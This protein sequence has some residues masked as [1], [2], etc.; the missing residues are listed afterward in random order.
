M[1]SVEQLFG[2]FSA[3]G[4]GGQDP[5]PK[6]TDKNICT[7]ILRERAKRASASET[8]PAIIFRTQNTSAYI[9]SMQFPL[10]MVWHFLNAH[11]CLFVCCLFACAHV[12]LNPC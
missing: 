8:A 9:Q 4:G 1:S 12:C 6:C 7:L 10:L 5:D 2:M 3:G 11:T